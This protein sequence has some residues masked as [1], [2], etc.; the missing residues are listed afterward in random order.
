MHGAFF[1][2]LPFSARRIGGFVARVAH[3][4]HFCRILPHPA[5]RIA[6]FVARRMPF[7]RFSPETAR[8]ILAALG[9]GAASRAAL[10]RPEGLRRSRGSPDPAERATEGLHKPVWPGKILAI[11]ASA[12]LSF[13]EMERYRFHPDGVLFYLTFS[14]VAWLPVFVNEAAF[15]IVTD[16]LVFCRH[17]K[18]LR[19]NAYV[20]MPTCRVT[21]T[22]SAS[23][24]V[25]K[26]QLFRRCCSTFGST[27][28]A[29]AAFR[30]RQ[31]TLHP[32]QVETE[33]FWQTKSWTI[34]MPPRA[35]QWSPGPSIGVFLPPV[36]GQTAPW[37]M[38]LC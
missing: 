22:P 6:G 33:D 31:P 16:G 35:G 13:G 19:S 2:F 1:R 14:V 20:I 11:P 37:I 23:T 26:P 30:S 28:T 21:C 38:T 27:P 4:P 32:V 29:T 5:R 10:R 12:L 8:R 25:G 24:K 15:K 18:R 3:T 34:C 9:V 36:P 17:E 7:F